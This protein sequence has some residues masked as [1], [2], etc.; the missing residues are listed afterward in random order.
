ML[1]DTHCLSVSA[2]LLKII[3]EQLPRIRAVFSPITQEYKL[4][5]AIFDENTEIAIDSFQNTKQPSEVFV[6]YIQLIMLICLTMH[7]GV[8]VP[9]LNNVTVS[10]ST[11]KIFWK[12]GVT[13]TF[14]FGILDNNF[15]AFTKYFFIRVFGTLSVKTINF[16]FLK[17]IYSQIEIYNRVLNDVSTNLSMVLQNLASVE[18]LLNLNPDAFFILLTCLPQEEINYF[19]LEIVQFI[20]DEIKVKTKNAT[21]IQ[22]NYLFQTPQYEM[23]LLLEKVRILYLLYTDAGY[24]S[25]KK[26]IKNEGFML[27][28]RILDN[29][30]IKKIMIDNLRV[31]Q[32]QEIEARKSLYSIV[33]KHYNLVK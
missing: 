13:D 9:E 22:V 20:P 7:K 18:K 25:V 17:T 23:R 26:I 28:L 11:I 29:N 12:T 32:E 21:D 24:L 1:V 31:N 6:C 3:S 16:Q 33:I 14:S 4:I 2:K 8:S 27:F 15:Y 19:F 10:G 5:R 30:K